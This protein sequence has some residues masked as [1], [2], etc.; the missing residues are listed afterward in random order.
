VSTIGR[1]VIKVVWAENGHRLIPPLIH[2]YVRYP[3][4]SW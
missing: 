3:Q 1:S 2:S 4:N